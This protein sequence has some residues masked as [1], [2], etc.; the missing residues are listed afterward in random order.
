MEERCK[1]VFVNENG[2]SIVEVE[3]TIDLTKLNLPVLFGQ[4]SIY[5]CD[6][7]FIYRKGYEQPFME[8]FN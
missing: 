4:M 7:G 1:I 6:A 3:T 8:I 2:K 5:K